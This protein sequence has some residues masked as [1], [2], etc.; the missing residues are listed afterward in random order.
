MADT[1][2]LPILYANIV[3]LSDVL[4][5]VTCICGTVLDVRDK[6]DQQH[7]TYMCGRCGHVAYTD[8]ERVG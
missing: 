2:L 5:G 4:T 7:G 6:L 1:C 8:G 3:L